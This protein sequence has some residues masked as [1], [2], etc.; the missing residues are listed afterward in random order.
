M[1]PLKLTIS[2]FG[3]YAR[4]QEIDFTSLN[5]QIFVI[6]GP[7]GAGKTT[8]FDAISFALFGEP[9]GSSRDRDS[10]RSDFAQPDSE[11]YVEL[12]FE[13][14]GKSYKIRRSPQQEQKKLR[15]EG[16]T[17]RNA[18]AELHMPDGALIT[19]ILSVDEKINELMGINKS[20]FKQIV[21]LPQ[22]EFRK[23]LEADSSERELIFRK[24]FGTEGFAEIQ[25][26]LEDES[27]ELYKALHDIKTEID[28][29]I[30]HFDLGNDQGLED[31]RTNKNVNI[32]QFIEAVKELSE[33]DQT[34]IQLLKSQ[35]EMITANQGALKEEI[36]KNIEINKKLGDREQ[37]KQ[38]YNL[39]LA[40]I[41]EFKQK[42]LSLEY[43]RKALPINE[44]DE[45]YK[46]SKQSVETKTGQLTLAKQQ[47]EKSSKDYDASKEIFIAEKGKEPLRKKYESELSLL[48]NMLTKVTNYEKSIKMLEMAKLKSNEIINSLEKDQKELELTKKS[49]KEQEENLK[50]LYNTESECVR[51]DKEISENKKLLIELDGTKKLIQ[52]YMEQ[53]ELYGSKKADFESFDEGFVAFRSKLEQQEDNYIRGQ[54]GILAK[55][56]KA[57]IPCPVC[58]A[59]EHPK[60]AK[61]LEAAPGEEQLKALKQEYTVLSEQ[62]THKLKL[63]SELGGNLEGKKLEIRNKL[64]ALDNQI[65][66]EFSKDGTEIKEDQLGEKKIVEFQAA[67]DELDETADGLQEIKDGHEEK[68]NILETTIENLSKVR[69]DIVQ[70]EIARKGISLKAE[71]LALMS[72]H[73]D[74]IEFVNK[75]NK[76]E[77]EYKATAGKISKLEDAVKLLT[78]QKLA[79]SEELARLSAAADS[80]EKEVPQDI[81]SAPKLNA[82]LE[83]MQREILNLEAEY[84]KAERARELAKEAF[85]NSE[86]EVAIK[87]TS[88]Q[89]SIEE[90]TRLDKLLNE[91]LLNG[92]FESYEHYRQ[93]KKTQAEL[94]TLQE[95]INTFHQKLKSLKD[96]LTRL[97]EETKELVLQDTDALEIKYSLLVEQQSK[98]QE[99]LNLVFSRNSNNSKTLAQLQDILRKLITLEEKYKLIGELSKV[100]RGENTQRITFERYVL[101]A[102]FD[103]IIIAANLRLDKMTG[104]RYLL[105][106]KEDKSKGR[107]QQ[108]LELE[109]FD[110]YTGKARHVKTLSGGEGF[111]ASLALAL[112]LA[113]VVQSYS[114][115]ISLDT[116]FV[117][118]GFGSLDPESL[119]NAI[120]CLVDIQKSGRLVGVISHVPEL[121]ERIKSVLEIFSQKEG[122]FARFVV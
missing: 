36:V 90:S 33:K 55:A 106:R 111:K 26:R 72:K 69:L 35:L 17:T 104:S 20:Q 94:L 19:K 6:S 113:D 86:K 115:G 73:K 42:E 58:G 23:L 60:P 10:F 21:M 49:Y 66:K 74:K 78:E 52:A 96:M 41:D 102:Y 25:K 70:A 45:Q 22:G 31:I 108:G 48:N 100:A 9:S 87:A 18:D 61:A 59:L 116:L 11:T 84:I 27:R 43:A 28:T 54:A 71:T 44:I 117:D 64:A 77:I 65:S 91:K 57:N 82:K 98:L 47:A 40:R 3:P 118:E 63:I 14:R 5:E 4:V 103:E 101:A 112:G 39:T 67:K 53:T 1:K 83:E 109:V 12:V 76:Y 15:G 99:V 79:I 110:N 13:L 119:D 80:I 24:I 8:I 29:H 107:A 97:E 75:K 121:K 81:R 34:E 30:K 7:T 46:N 92:S 114:G 93:M 122:S 88:L 105:K 50:Q 89:E 120:Q 38:E 2:A 32:E 85:S 56:L 68:A 95:E 37:I 51:L 62:R 16:Y